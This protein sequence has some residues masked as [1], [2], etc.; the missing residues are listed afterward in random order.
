MQK[1]QLFTQYKIFI[2]FKETLN[3]Q[4]HQKGRTSQDK[5][6][7]KWKVEK[8]DIYDIDKKIAQR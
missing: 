4:K 2:N 3:Q 6:K 1:F 7:F 8:I 5:R